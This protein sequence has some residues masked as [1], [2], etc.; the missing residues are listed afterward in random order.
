MAAPPPSGEKL[1]I[2]YQ[3][4]RKTARTPPLLSN[5]KRQGYRDPC[6]SGLAS[7]DAV[8]FLR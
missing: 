6:L 3:Q 5:E 7:P 2:I 1:R 4:Y 8:G